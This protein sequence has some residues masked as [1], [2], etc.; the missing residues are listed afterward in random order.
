M[1]IYTADDNGEE[2][3]IRLEKYNIKEEQKVIELMVSKKPIKVVLDP[4]LLLIDKDLKDNELIVSQ[5]N[6]DN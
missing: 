5:T 4:H 6:N 1:G 3:L 2:S